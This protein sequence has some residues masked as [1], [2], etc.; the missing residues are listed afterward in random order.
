LLDAVIPAIHGF[1]AWLRL[2]AFSTEAEI[3]RGYFG[4]SAGAR[5]DTMEE[6]PTGNILSQLTNGEAVPFGMTRSGAFFNGC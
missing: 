3:K 2:L 5:G 6:I 4:G 1:G